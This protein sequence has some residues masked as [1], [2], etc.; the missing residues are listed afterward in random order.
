FS[1]KPIDEGLFG[2]RI[3]IV[4]FLHSLIS[5][6]SKATSHP[7]A[8][9]IFRS[10]ESSLRMG[11]VLLMWINTFRD[12]RTFDNAERLPP[13]P[14]T[15]QYASSSADFPRKPCADSSELDQKVPSKR[16]PSAPSSAS[17]TAGV[18]LPTVERY[19]SARRFVDS[20]N[21]RPT[22]TASSIVARFSK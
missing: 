19:A 8:S 20:R 12:A 5:I 4:V 2:K 9:M 15:G 17:Y 1:R 18:M 13:S 10:G 21:L 11:L 6:P 14:P 16:I 22:F 3:P 7:A